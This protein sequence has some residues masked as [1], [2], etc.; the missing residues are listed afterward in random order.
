MKPFDREPNLFEL[1]TVVCYCVGQG[2]S[3]CAPCRARRRA[4]QDMQSASMSIGAFLAGPAAHTLPAPAAPPPAAPA[5]NP[6]Y[7]QPVGQTKWT[8]V[9][10]PRQ[11]ASG[12]VC[13]NCQNGFMAP[14][15]VSKRLM[16]DNCKWGNGDAMRS[17]GTQGTPLSGP[18][19]IFR[20]VKARI[21]AKGSVRGL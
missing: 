17:L 12:D 7:V 10:A 6:W 2:A 14:H 1:P 9:P 8:P 19:E 21:D 11:L 4:E 15:A 16:C 20:R 13:P 18:Q 5:P 3:R